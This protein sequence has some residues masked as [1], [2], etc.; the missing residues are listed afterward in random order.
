MCDSSEA[1]AQA[2][3]SDEARRT[4]IGMMRALSILLLFTAGCS[5]R[6]SD[7]IPAPKR[8]AALAIRDDVSG[9]QEWG[10]RLHTEPFLQFAYTSYVY[11][12]EDGTF[13]LHQTLEHE[14]RSL[15]ERHD[16]VDLFVLAHTSRYLHS[17]ERIEPELRG[18][19]RLIYN[20]GAGDLQQ[21]DRWIELGARAYVG[22]PGANNAPLFYVQFLPLW[23]EGAPLEDAVAEANVRTKEAML[24]LPMRGTITLA[25][26]FGSHLRSAEEV[27]L[28]TEAGIAGD[29]SLRND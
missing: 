28:G 6:P 20:T 21:A 7:H 9:W 3:R 11:L 1:G 12:E 16:R 13:D 23:L 5:L 26:K 18:K 2:R 27:W 24:S 17:V 14:L 25:Q 19:L 4:L 8:T 15:L 29:R 10:T 22:H